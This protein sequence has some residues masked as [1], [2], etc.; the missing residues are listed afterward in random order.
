MNCKSSDQQSLKFDGVSDCP[1][2]TFVL[3]LCS[4]RSAFG[5]LSARSFGNRGNAGIAGGGLISSCSFVDHGGAG[6]S[7]GTCHWC[8]G[9]KGSLCTV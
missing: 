2:S 1:G 6:D 8:N 4:S 9:A 5:A 7:D 3:Y